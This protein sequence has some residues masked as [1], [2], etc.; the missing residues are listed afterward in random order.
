MSERLTG[1]QLACA[2]QGYDPVASR[3][4]STG[5]D[6]YIDPAFLEAERAEIFRRSWQFLCH[7]EK[8]RALRGASSIVP[9][10][11]PCVRTARESHSHVV[12]DES[13]TWAGGYYRQTSSICL[14]SKLS[15][16]DMDKFHGKLSE[17]ESL[18]DGLGYRGQ[19]EDDNG[20]KAF[21]SEDKAVLNWW[22][23]TGTL[24][25]Q[26]PATPK[27]KFEEAMTKAL[28]GVPSASG[29]SAPT[30]PDTFIEKSSPSADPANSSGGESQKVFVVYGHDEAA[31]DQL[32][33]VLRRLHL[34]P[35]VLGNTAGGG[36]T[37]IE[38]LENEIL[39]SNN[40]RRFG[41]V[42]MT[43]D[44]MGYK[45]GDDPANAEPRARQNVVMEMGMLIAAFGRAR[46]AILKK[47]HVEVPSDARG[48]IY[49]PF[50]SHVKE[51]TAKLCQRL[52]E[53]GFEFSSSAI[54]KAS[55]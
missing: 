53:A 19:W 32:E 52:E 5:A 24:Q 4:A 31:C 27:S 49:L 42:L 2:G 35:F 54:A 30:A 39:S 16:G 17:L 11:R 44:D 3:S 14:Q 45:Q 18:V 51:T 55:A 15:G 8:L 10:A 37:I 41:I 47:G 25:I 20:K 48:I 26:G 46:V 34:D 6:C 36:L 7:D 22:P 21:R 43:P 1:E 13:I 40:G 28:A 50:N 29:V 33:L 38:A 9:P 12:V 23:S